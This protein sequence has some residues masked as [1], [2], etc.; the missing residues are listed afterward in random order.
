MSDASVETDVA[1]AK[2]CGVRGGQV[3]LEGIVQQ[4][5]RKIKFQ[6]EKISELRKELTLTKKREQMETQ[7]DEDA[8]S[9]QIGSIGVYVAYVA[10]RI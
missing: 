9:G 2:S 8:K 10:Y 3:T 7:V 4:L 1:T 6:S 5:L